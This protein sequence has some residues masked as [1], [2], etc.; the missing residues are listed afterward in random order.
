M[1]PAFANVFDGNAAG[2]K[3]FTP[4]VCLHC[5]AVINDRV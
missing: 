1:S 5:W 2:G 4:Q 3:D